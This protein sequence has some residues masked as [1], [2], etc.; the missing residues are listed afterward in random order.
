[1]RIC[2]TKG[3]ACAAF[4]VFTALFAFAT[5]V[6]AAA[7]IRGRTDKPGVAPVSSP[8]FLDLRQRVTQPTLAFV[9]PGQGSQSVG[10]LAELAAVHPEVR[11]AFAEASEGAGVDL[12][13]LSQEG[14][15]ESLNRTEF[16]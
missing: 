12:W 5:H 1:R 9:F 15:E 16:T 6:A 8:S 11:A 13:A 2:Q 7:D 3:R 4:R 14:P 10:M